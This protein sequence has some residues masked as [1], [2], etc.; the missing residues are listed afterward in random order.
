[1]KKIFEPVSLG[2]LTLKNRIIRS[3]TLTNK[4]CADGVMLPY[5]KESCAALAKGN[6]AL[7]ITGM[8]GIGVNY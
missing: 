1:M 2:N 8:M 5:L 4:D 6:V 7:I 3:A